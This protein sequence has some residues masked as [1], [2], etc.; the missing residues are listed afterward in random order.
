[1]AYFVFLRESGKVEGIEWF[2]TLADALEFTPHTHAADILRDDY[3][4]L[5][6]V[7]RWDFEQQKWFN[8]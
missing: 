3:P 2:S 8:Y 1:M 5:R 6:P 7:Y 4:Y